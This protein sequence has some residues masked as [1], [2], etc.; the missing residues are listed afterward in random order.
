[1]KALPTLTTHGFITDETLLMSKL[2]EYFLTTQYSQSVFYKDYINSYDKIIKNSPT[3][4]NKLEY[5]LSDA[6]YKLYNRYFDDVTP[7][8]RLEDKNPE[9]ETAYRLYIDIE[10]VGSDGR[11]LA[12]SKVLVTTDGVIQDLD[13]IINYF[14]K[15]LS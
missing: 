10:C 3:V 8:V 14:K 13:D 6:L 1:M 9:G 5:E 4:S 7:T 2:Y 15:E 12:L 11:K